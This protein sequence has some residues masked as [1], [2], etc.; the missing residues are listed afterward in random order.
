MENGGRGEDEGTAAGVRGQAGEVA[1]GMEDQ[2]EALR[3]YA[4]DA[5]EVIRS[6]ARERPWAAIGIAAGVGFLLGR[7]LSRT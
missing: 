6:F 7:M 3:G 2:L 1:A 5:G 4:E